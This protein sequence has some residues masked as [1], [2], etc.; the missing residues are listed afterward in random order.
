[1]TQ[2]MDQYSSVMLVNVAKFW[3]TSHNFGEVAVVKKSIFL[4][5]K[6]VLC[7]AASSNMAAPSGNIENLELQLLHQK[8][9]YKAKNW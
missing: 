1:M 9:N 5:L 3:L 2:E 6:R 7:G 8:Y 4:E